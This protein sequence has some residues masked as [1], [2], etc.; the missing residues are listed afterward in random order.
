MIIKSRGNEHDLDYMNLF[1]KFEDIIFHESNNFI[2][3]KTYLN[4]MDY[5]QYDMIYAPLNN[6]IQV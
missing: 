3:I 1:H 2:L 4:T 6:C 5:M